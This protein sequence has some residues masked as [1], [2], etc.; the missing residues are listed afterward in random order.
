MKSSVLNETR[1]V[2]KA[3]TTLRLFARQ[4]LFKSATTKK[5]K[6]GNRSRAVLFHTRMRYNRKHTHTDRKK[7]RKLINNQ[8]D[9]TTHLQ[10]AFTL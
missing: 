5:K 8:S 1:T 2:C 9:V 3:L 6:S 7:R 10:T 4:K